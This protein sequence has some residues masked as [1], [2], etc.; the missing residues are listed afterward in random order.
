[1][2]DEQIREMARAE[3][4]HWYF[5]SRRRVLGAMIAELGPAGPVL[6]VG[7][8]TGGNA[9]LL[10]PWA[11]LHG[12]DRS[13]PAAR[14]SLARGYA[15]A[16]IADGWRLPFPDG[17]FPVVTCLDVL[18]HLR[19]DVAA[20]AELRRVCRPGGL[21][22]ATVPAFQ[23]LWSAHDVALGHQRRYTR[24]QVERLFAGA[25]L[26]LR[27]LTYCLLGTFLPA[28]VVRTAQRLARRGRPLPAGGKTD[29]DG[30]PLPG[31][32]NDLIA[33]VLA[34]EARWVARRDLPVGLSIF[35]AGERPVP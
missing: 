35:A 12:V 28:A 2:Q 10:A 30:F 6:D 7:C 32:V 9:E 23:W 8:G 14:G 29:V 26:R 20:A 1:M 5:R 16:V 11:P 33:G 31:L 21:V 25:G 4:A 15:S 18:E 13:P 3:G 24:A 27:R 19:D 22:V 17:T 34:Q